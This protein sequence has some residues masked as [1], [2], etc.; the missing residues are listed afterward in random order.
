[1][2]ITLVRSSTTDN[3]I[4]EGRRLRATASTRY[5][6]KTNHIN[7]IS[8]SYTSFLPLTDVCRCYYYFYFYIVS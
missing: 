7:L 1:M 3:N 2:E 8:T 4:D 5:L 6:I